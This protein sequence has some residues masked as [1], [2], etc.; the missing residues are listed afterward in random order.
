M[1]GG[2]QL[3]EELKTTLEDLGSME[4]GNEEMKENVEVANEHV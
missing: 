4:Y 2:Y 3:D 1:D